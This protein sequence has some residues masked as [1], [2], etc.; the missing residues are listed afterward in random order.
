MAQPSSSTAQ[1]FVLHQT[2]KAGDLDGLNRSLAAGMD[3]NA[4][5]SRGHTALMYAVDKGYVLLV[6][7][8]LAAQADPNVRAPDGATALFIA[9]VHGHS[10]IIPMLMQAGADPAIKGPKG[11]TAMEVAQLKYGDLEAALK[12]REAPAVIAL[13]K[14]ETWEQ[15]EDAVFARVRSRGTSDAYAEYLAAFP[16]GRYVEKSR[17]LANE[18]EDTEAF[19]RARSQGTSDAYAE[20]LAAFP[21]GRY[22][23]LSRRLANEAED[24]E[25]FAMARSQGTADAYA[26]YI[27]S[28]PSG[29]HVEKAGRLQ[30]EQEGVLRAT[31]P[32]GTTLRECGVCPEMVV[33]PAGRFQMG[34]LSGEG[35]G[36]EYPVHRVTIDYPFA[37]GR[38]EVTFAEWDACVVAGGCTHQPDD[39]YGGRGTRPVIDVSWD[40]VQEYVKWLS[41]ETGKPY[42]LLSEAEWEYMARAETT[43]KYWWGNEASHAH[44]NYGKD[45]C[46]AGLAAGR[47]R[48]VKTSPV[49]SFEPNAFGLYDTAGNVW[50]WV[51]DCFH[52]NYEGAPADGSAWT[53]DDCSE[54]VLHGGSYSSHPMTLRS[55]ARGSRD[56]SPGF[57]SSGRQISFGFR[58]A[59]TLTP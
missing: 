51:E 40:D 44:A 28:Y 32:R 7:P 22:V 3:V 11:K 36:N 39:L 50:E 24:T 38:Y 5:D 27:A 4:R 15:F 21:D 37:V 30:A 42:R 52:D 58:V 6:E 48:W 41:R 8:L 49:G 16:D 57:F 23:G 29:R 13:L 55:A 33:V 56:P 53:S 10:E 47:D 34:D 26:E 1:S 54:R 45:E 59:R 2:V 31:S 35:Y 14:G 12:R 17:R 25:A 46:C 20:Y 43:T 9:V 18:A 19:A